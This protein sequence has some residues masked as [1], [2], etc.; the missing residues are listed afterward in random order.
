MDIESLQLGKGMMA[1]TLIR[2][3][4]KNYEVVTYDT[5]KAFD[6]QSVIL[7]ENLFRDYPF[8][9][10][11]YRL[12]EASRP[13]T[14]MELQ[15]AELVPINAELRRDMELGDLYVSRSSDEESAA[16]EHDNIVSE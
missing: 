13:Y 1:R 15:L 7:W 4:G 11:V 2:D 3:G 8:E 10:V 6:E 12:C 14:P 5:K 9:T 16:L